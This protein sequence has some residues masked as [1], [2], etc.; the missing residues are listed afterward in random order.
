VKTTFS[1]ILC[2]FIVVFA[3]I[4]G[5][6]VYHL[7]FPSNTTY[8]ISALILLGLG[9]FSLLSLLSSRLYVALVLLKNA[10]ILNVIFFSFFIFASLLLAMGAGLSAS[11]LLSM[12]YYFLIFP[13]IFVF[14]RFDD[15]LLT[16]I[17][18]IITF[19]T[20][21]GVY[22]IFDLGANSGGYQNGMNAIREAHSILRPGEFKYSRLGLNLLPFGYTGSHIDTANIL[23]MCGI[24][25][26]T[27]FF[28]CTHRIK[29]LLYIGCYFVILSA[30][31][32]TG[33][34]ANVLVL[35][36]I[37]IV[38]LFYYIQ[39][40]PTT[41]LVSLIL[42]ITLFFLIASVIVNMDLAQLFQ[43]A[44]V[45]AKF[46]PDT[47]SEA[48]WA[49]LDAQSI[50]DSLMSVAFGFGET[51]NSPL[52]LSEVAFVSLLSRFG[53]LSFVT[54]MVIGF[55][56]IYY[57]FVFR[58]NRNRRIE[59]LKMNFANN[60]TA[61]FIQDSRAQ[62]FRLFYIAMPVLAGFLTLIHYASVFRITSIGLFCVLLSIFL[63]EYLKA[64]KSLESYPLEKSSNL[65]S[66]ED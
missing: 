19:I 65:M 26:L 9:V 15:K 7:G 49:S 43:L 39:K 57:F 10:V 37:S 27:K 44:Y 22:Y 56:P 23:V 45:F 32:L 55:S 12:F 51:L 61:H 13:T 40:S 63:K 58:L 4:R 21:V 66:M 33:S 62:K 20:V 29:S 35:L 60:L 48:L 5:A 53:L 1:H 2:A 28:I 30:T 6:F 25:F 47:M 52:I 34:A 14:L 24:F 11:S 64:H 36:F 59:F 50:K 46:N 41:M 8:T 18:Y 38:S 31:L 17:V 3:S 42:I 54:L 16:R